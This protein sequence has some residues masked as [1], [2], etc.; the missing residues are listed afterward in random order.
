MPK[1]KPDL[2]AYKVVRREIDTALA[3]AERRVAELRA[4]RE[5]LMVVMREEG[6]T[7]DQIGEVFE[8]TRNRAW[9]KLKAV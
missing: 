4:Q 7:Y 1:T 2:A 6:C 9:Q 3:I 8:V 5:R